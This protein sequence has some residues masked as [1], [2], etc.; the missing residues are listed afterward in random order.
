MYSPPITITQRIIKYCIDISR[1]LG[2]SEGIQ[3]PEPKP[4]LRRENQIKT[5]QSTLAI[6]GNQFSLDQVTAIIEGKRVLGKEAEI[7]EVQN[8][9]SVYKRI[10]D[11]KPIKINSMLKAH[12]LLMNQLIDSPGSWRTGNVGI[13]KGKKISHVAPPASRVPR[14]MNDLFEYL[15]K[16][17]ETDLLIKACIFHYQFLFI[18]P[19]IDGNGRIAR[20]WQQLIL[21]SQH[22]IFRHVSI[23]SLIKE[24]QKEYY[25]M[26]ER[27]D[28]MGESTVFVEFMLRLILLELDKLVSTLRQKK[29]TSSDRIKQAHDA[30]RTNPF[31]RKDYLELFREISTATASRDLKKAVDK[32]YLIK[33]GSKA[34]TVYCFQ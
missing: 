34:T 4:K 1:L 6:E 15:K 18:H 14:L 30:F 13:I 12:K 7:I 24:N 19:F 27:S 32:G 3:S 5:I 10:G 17:K 23:E 20:L 16:E 33:E 28:K 25:Q 29:T 2:Y 22:E 31:S 9:I 8:T 21:I 26:L 11:W